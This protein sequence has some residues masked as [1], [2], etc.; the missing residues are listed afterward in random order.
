MGLGITDR[1]TPVGSTLWVGHRQTVLCLGVPHE[2]G[3]ES[4]CAQK[5]WLVRYNNRFPVYWSK[6]IAGRMG[7]QMMVA[8]LRPWSNV[9]G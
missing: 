2:S 7:L 9:L 6:G 8:D 5:F 1:K 4:S 3:C